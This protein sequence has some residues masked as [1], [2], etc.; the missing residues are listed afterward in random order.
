MKKRMMMAVLMTGLFLAGLAQ[1]QTNVSITEN[2]AGKVKMGMTVAEVRRVV[3]PMKLS[4]TRDGDGVILIA[5][6]SGKSEVMTLFAGEADADENR[7]NEQAKIENIEVW[8]KNYQTAD[9]I[10]PGMLLSAV[11]KKYGKVKEIM[12]SEIESREYAEFSNFPARLSL[13]LSGKDSQNAGVYAQGSNR[14]KR[15]TAGTYIF[16]ITV[17]SPPRETADESGSCEVVTKDANG[18][19]NVRNTPGGTIIGKLPN[20]TQVKIIERSSG[21][22]RVTATVG[23]KT[24][25]GWVANTFLGNCS[26]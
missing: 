15:Y 12:M 26:N 4:R 19:L 22:A 23:G 11:E 25:E 17:S 7:I 3:S 18:N 6:K 8:A 10:H 16:S 14:T 21:A 13:R 20:G 24:I 9:G 1:A 5:V 2:S